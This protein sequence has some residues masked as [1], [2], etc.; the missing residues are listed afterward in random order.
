MSPT[1]SR[2]FVIVVLV[3]LFVI[4]AIILNAATLG[5]LVKRFDELKTNNGNQVNQLCSS[6][7]E[8][9]RIDDVMGHL[10]ELYRIA[11]A[12][13]NTRAINTRGFNRTLDYITDYLS[14]HTNYQIT[15]TYFPINTFQL[16]SNPILSIS[17]NGIIT[18][19]IYSMDLSQAEFF[20]VEYSGPINL[21]DF[22]GLTAISNVGCSDADW[23]SAN[24]SPV[25]G[26]IA[27]V[28]RGVCDFVDKAAFATKYNAMG[29]L[30]Y[31]DGSSSDRNDPI[32]IS[33]DQNNVLPALFLSFSLGE[34]LVTALQNPATNTSARIIIDL[35][36]IPPFPVANICADTPTGDIGQ[37]IVVG[38][39]SDSVPAGPGINDNGKLYSENQNLW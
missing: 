7:V 27:L 38:S 22:I 31:N 5:V 17:I 2:V 28:K 26:R 4:I 39:H 11:V 14:T 37:T 20:H 29:I 12:E 30:I 9:I 25:A 33:L 34:Q 8:A 23:L 6:L 19:R 21:T 10:S 3:G 16:A 13:N 32:A 18:N 36:D 35:L 1:L 15:K 24:P